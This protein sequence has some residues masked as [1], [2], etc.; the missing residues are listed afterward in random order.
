[1]AIMRFSSAIAIVVVA[2]TF[3]HKAYAEQLPEWMKVENGLSISWTR[4]SAAADVN[5][6]SISNLSGDPSRPL[7]TLNVLRI[8]PEAMRVTVYDV[9]ARGDLIAVAAVYRSKNV[10]LRNTAALLLFNFKGDLLSLSALAP[11]HSAELLVIDDNSHIWS[12]TGGPGK[13]INPSKVPMVVEY[14][15]KGKVLK[16]LLPRSN[17]PFHATET[18][19]E[20]SIG[21]PSMGYD[22]GLVWIWL[23]GST[24]LITISTKDSTF[25]TVKTGLPM[26]EGKKLVPIALFRESS[27]S[28]SVQVGKEN[29]GLIEP[30]YYTWSPSARSWSNFRPQNCDGGRLIGTS[31]KQQVYLAHLDSQ[32]TVH[33]LC[34]SE[35]SVPGRP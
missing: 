27:G 19:G 33:K 6:I 9:S 30:A 31:E 16:E 34:T 14:S 21:F 17:F 2:C 25:T 13:G 18:K 22:S 5:Q 35:M 29:R 1:M 24:D 4:V 3:C 12:L 20:L 26:S 15:S 8:V 7:L 23:P 28:V 10:T 11:S 32:R